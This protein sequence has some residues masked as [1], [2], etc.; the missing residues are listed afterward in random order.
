MAG[1]R[2]RAFGGRPVLAGAQGQ[3]QS[4][5]LCDWGASMALEWLK[6]RRYRHFDL[7]VNEAFA[8]KVISPAVVSRHAFS[9]LIHY[10]KIETRYKKCPKTGAR[11]ITQKPRPIKYAAH[12]D[13]CILSYYAHQ[14]NQALDVQLKI[15][16]ISDN[17]IAYRALGQANYDFAAEAMAFAQAAAPVVILAF[18]ITS[19][20]DTLD[21]CLLKRRLKSLLGVHELADDWHKVFRFIT[22]FHYVD[23]KELKAHPRFGQRLKERSRDRIASVEELKAE[24]ITFHANPELAKGYRRGIPQGTPISATASNLYMIE[25]DAAA[26]ACCDEVGAFYRRYSDDI[27]IICKPD[28]APAIEAEILRLIAAEKLNIAP[29]KTEKTLFEKGRAVPRTTKAAQYLGFTFDESGPAIRESS[30]ARQ[31]RKMRRAMLRAQKSAFWRAKVGLPSKVH[32]KKLYRRFAYIKINDGIS[33]R[34][35][36]NFSSYGR[37]SAEAFGR[38]EKISRQVKRLERA[39]LREISKLKAL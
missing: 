6:T 15:T 34:A 3:G 22:K 26:R 35:L 9:P 21:H 12:R 32:T 30:L 31:W 17:V 10:T 29:H 24:G 5:E 11:T 23:L 7:P 25:F 4:P 27:L 38:D 33:P 19:F 20:F 18:D 1:R 37:R 14:I 2:W 28:D 8:Q 13:A 36:R 16:G 39:A